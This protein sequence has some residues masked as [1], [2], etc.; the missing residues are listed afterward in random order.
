MKRIKVNADLYVGDDK[1]ATLKDIN[2]SIPFVTP[3]M[4]GA[5]SDGTTDDVTAIQNAID[6]CRD[7]GNVLTFASGKTY[8]IKKRIVLYSNIT[9]EAYGATIKKGDVFDN[10]FVTDKYQN[11]PTVTNNSKNITIMGGTFDAGNTSNLNF[12][13]SMV[14]IFY[15]VDNLTLKDIN[16]KSET[17]NYFFLLADTNNTYINNIR[18]NV[19]K[20]C[21]HLSGLNY[22]T[23]IENIYDDYSGDDCV[24]VTTDDGVDYYG[25]VSGD[26]EDLTSRNIYTNNSTRS[27]LLGNTAHVI[28]N[29]NVDNIHQYG[30]GASFA[31]GSG[32][33]CFD[34]NIIFYY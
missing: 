5:K 8:L 32:S 34:D 18:F 12:M 4:F 11:K 10:M 31:M 21:I 17:S 7:N 2:D 22:K 14:F 13:T 19:Y 6:Y 1:L 16:C 15:G 9:I 25:F 24:A 29:V 27:V 23:V 26:V 20:D 28:K 30:S 33:T 3:E